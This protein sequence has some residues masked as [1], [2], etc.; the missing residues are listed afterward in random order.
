MKYLLILLMIAVIGAG[1]MYRDDITA[2]FTSEKES[3]EKKK[4]KGKKDVKKEAASNEVQVIAQW[5]LPERLKEIS[6]LSYITAEKFACVQDEEGVMFIYNIQDEKIEKEIPFGGSGDY[7]GITLVNNTAYIVRSDGMLFEIDNWN[8]K[9]STKQ[10]QTGLTAKHNVEGL[11]YDKQGNRL[12]LGIKDNEASSKDHKGV[13]AFD[14]DSKTFI[15]TPVYKIDLTHSALSQGKKKNTFKPSA[16]AVHPSSQ[17]LFI[18][19]GP[20]S[21]LMVMDK[22]GGIKSVLNLGSSFEQPEGITFSP[23]GDIF[24]SNEGVNEPG[25]IIKI[26]IQ[27]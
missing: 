24:I 5:Q 15:E 14:L 3:K 18:V 21:R 22:Q 7:E 9:P 26:T 4:E 1:Y 2:S 11:V 27:R 10:Y 17:E 12:L 16:I 8:N 23:G 6:G 25:N 19:D 13:Y 20:A